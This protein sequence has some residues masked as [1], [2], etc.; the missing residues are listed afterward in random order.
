MGA[1]HGA[2][3][4]AGFST[5]RL[6]DLFILPEYRRRGIGAA[7]FNAI[8]EWAQQHEGTRYLEWQASQSA[9]DFY[10]QLGY[11][12]DPCPQPEYPFFEIDFT[13]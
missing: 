3:L 8:K 4:R 12:G 7:L 10:Q 5:A 9:L 6:H 11:I 2:H 13:L 1:R